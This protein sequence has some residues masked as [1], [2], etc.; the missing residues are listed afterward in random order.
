M[1]IDNPKCLLTGLIIWLALAM[2][3]GMLLG[4]YLRG[5]QD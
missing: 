1:S 2:L 5:R 4:R 3:A